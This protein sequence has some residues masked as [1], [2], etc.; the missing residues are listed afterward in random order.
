MISIKG[1]RHVKINKYKTMAKEKI[2]AEVNLNLTIPMNVDVKTALQCE[3]IDELREY[4]KQQVIK[5]VDA[6]VRGKEY[7][8]Y[9]DIIFS[10]HESLMEKFKKI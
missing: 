6:T 4:L 10:N 3:D 8:M 5:S 9:G 2:F 1:I 7:D